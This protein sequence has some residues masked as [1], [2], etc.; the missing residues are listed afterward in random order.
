MDI[1]NSRVEGFKE[2]IIFEVSR[3][4][5]LAMEYYDELRRKGI[6][7]D[8]DNDPS[9]E[10]TSETNNTTTTAETELNWNEAE[11][12]ICPRLARNLPD[13]P[14]SFKNYSHKDVTKISKLD[15]F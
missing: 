3:N 11:G 7:V 15:C 8:G 13:T 5:N 6:E 2:R 10:N 4:R 14:A 1:R 12:I 9:P